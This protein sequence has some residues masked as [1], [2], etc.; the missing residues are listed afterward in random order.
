MLVEI[1][2]ECKTVHN[3]EIK[4]VDF[5]R[6]FCL[7]DANTFLPSSEIGDRRPDNPFLSRSRDEFED[8]AVFIIRSRE[9]KDGKRKN[10]IISG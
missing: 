4:E 10:E 7:C 3:P 6:F 9:R 2:M 1:L 5:P 8:E